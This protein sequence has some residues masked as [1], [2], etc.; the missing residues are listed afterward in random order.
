[1]GSSGIYHKNFTNRQEGFEQGVLYA[2]ARFLR[3]NFMKNK[4]L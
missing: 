3:K 2:L 1:M 4:S